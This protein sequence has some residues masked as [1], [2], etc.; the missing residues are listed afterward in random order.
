MNSF[1]QLKSG[2]IMQWP[3]VRERRFETEVLEFADGSEQRFRHSPAGV[4]QWIVRLDDLDEG[5]LSMLESFFAQEQ[6]AFGTFSF[7]DPWDGTVYATCRFDNPACVAEYRAFHRGG[8]TL[9]V[10]E[11]R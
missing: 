1:P 11:V 5:E 4:R 7:T 3:A 9:I 6:G 8:T 10:R 2:A